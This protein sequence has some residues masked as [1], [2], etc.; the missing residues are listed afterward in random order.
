MEWNM[1]LRKER[2]GSTSTLPAVAGA[3]AA[4]HRPT[5]RGTARASDCSLTRCTNNAVSDGLVCLKF[6]SFGCVEHREHAV[7]QVFAP[8]LKRP[9][10][11]TAPS[12]VPPIVPPSIDDLSTNDLFFPSSFLFF[13][14][15]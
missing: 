7:G 10:E 4:R 8:P 13:P 9:S 14:A 12:L 15:R 11:R 3:A 6:G 5:A 2:R 1:H